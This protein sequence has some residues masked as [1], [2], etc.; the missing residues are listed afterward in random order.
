[1]DIKKNIEA[2]VN[3]LCDWI[4]KEA[5]KVTAD[6]DCI[7]FSEVCRALPELVNSLNDMKGDGVND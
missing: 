2:T 4:Q 7:V 3:C 1:M 5:P 6:G